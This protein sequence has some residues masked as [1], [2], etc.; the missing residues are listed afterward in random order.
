MKLLTTVVLLLAS[1]DQTHA[2]SRSQAEAVKPIG[3][4]VAIQ[5][6]A[7]TS[8]TPVALRATGSCAS[9]GSQNCT[10]DMVPTAADLI[11]D[12]TDNTELPQCLRLSGDDPCSLV[13]YGPLIF[14]SEKHA[15]QSFSAPSDAVRMTVSLRQ[16]RVHQTLVDLPPSQRFPLN[17]GRLFDVLRNRSAAA[18]RLECSMTDGD[19]RIFPIVG[20]TDLSPNIRFVSKNSSEPLFDILTY[21]VMP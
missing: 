7:T 8:E 10:A 2:Q 15:T 17:P 14:Q 3:T 18:A 4:C 19:Q 16:K 9:S 1:V 6:N 12:V 20:N 13:Q 5:T 21:R 11:L